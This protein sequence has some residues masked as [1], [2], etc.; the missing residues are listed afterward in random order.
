MKIALEIKYLPNLRRHTKFWRLL[1]WNDT[2]W[3]WNWRKQ[4]FSNLPNSNI[5][6]LISRFEISDMRCFPIGGMKIPCHFTVIC[7]DWRNHNF[8]QSP[9]V[10]NLHSSLLFSLLLIKI[11]TFLFPLLLSISEIIPSQNLT[12]LQ[13]R[14][15]RKCSKSSSDL[16]AK[17]S[18]AKI[19]SVEIW[20]SRKTSKI[21]EY[22][23]SSPPHADQL[24]LKKTLP[25]VALSYRTITGLRHSRVWM[26][27]TSLLLS[28]ALY[29]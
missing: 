10:N 20:T 18:L 25:S 8:I 19:F 26:P 9:T 12:Q 27:R 5:N 28:F 24:V 11:W 3:W 7:Y 22:S 23:H 15:H 14:F 1:D 16:A 29:S 2:N 21:L 4:K 17:R 13:N 6:L